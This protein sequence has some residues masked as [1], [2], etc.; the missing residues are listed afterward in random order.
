MNRSLYFLVLI[1]FSCNPNKTKEIIVA[2][3]KN[4]NIKILNKYPDSKDTSTYISK[5]Y[6]ANG[7]L[8]QTVEF[9]NSMFVN[10]KITYFKNQNIYQIDSL[11][12]PQSRENGNWS[13]QVTRYYANG[14][15]AQQYFVK[16]SKTEGLFKNYNDSGKIWEEFEVI[17]T[18]KNG[19]FTAYYDNGKKSYQTYYVMG[20]HTGME[21]HFKKSGDTL[22]YGLYQDDKYRFPYKLWLKNGNTLVGNYFNKSETEVK[23]DWYDSSGRKVKTQIGHSFKGHFSVPY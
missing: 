18:I 9:R 17:D 20:K 23:W 3:Y 16:N 5:V 14:N 6:F 2:R 1:L 10:K 19:V 12:F 4:G 7:N 21:Y 15:I 13:G 8:A 22:D 11:Y